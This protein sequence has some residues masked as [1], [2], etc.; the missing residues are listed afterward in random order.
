MPAFRLFIPAAALAASA[1]LLAACDDEPEAAAE[2]IRAIKPYFVVEPTGGA[3]R[4]YS[5]T[6]AAAE[7]SN[8]SFAVSGTVASVLVSNGDRVAKGQILATLDP[9]SL[10]LDVQ[11][12][13]SQLASARA[14][15]E[16]KKA[17]L[18]RKRSLFN[19]GWVA[20]AALDTASNAY[21]AARGELSLARSRLGIA[22]RDRENAKLTAPFDG[23][24]S[25][26][27]IEPFA[28]VTIGQKIF[29]LDS[30]GAF[31]VE[32][33]VSDSVIGQISVGAPV[34]IEA[35]TNSQ[36]G[37]TGRVTEIGAASGAANTVPV[38]ATIIDS[39]DGLVS[40]MAVEAS[41][42][43]KSEAGPRGF[44]VPLVAIAPGDGEARGYVFKFDKDA[45]VVRKTPVMSEGVIQGNLVGITEGVQAGDIV[46]SAGVSL[47]RDGQ[48]VTL[49]GE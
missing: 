5:G 37:C 34:T 11:A 40:G 6:I 38:T 12:A 44:L 3:V 22:E 21:E 4:R 24:I 45:G 20:K 16:D 26:R 33:S 27:E 30:Q 31:E 13:R 36:C 46:A 43:L 47:L 29:Q 2:R 28:E 7:T 19:K 48:R 25:S 39:P 41:I 32:L 14:Q 17:D 23:V 49:L 10:D 15:T 8:L 9:R 18:A 35:S 42:V 1:V